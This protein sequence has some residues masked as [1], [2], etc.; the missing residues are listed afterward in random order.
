MKYF[1]I[2]RAKEAQRLLAKKVERAHNLGRVNNV[3]GLDVS[4]SK[5]VGTAVAAL[6]DFPQLSL[7]GYAIVKEVVDIPYIPGLLA[8]REAPLMIK[9]YKTLGREA[10]LIVVDGHGVTHPRE[11]GVASHVG[12]ALNKPTI[13]V[14]KGLLYGSIVRGRDGLEYIMVN[15]K[16]GGLVHINQGRKLYVSIGHKISMESLK[17]IIPQLF[18][19]HHLPEPIYIADTLSKK[20]RRSQ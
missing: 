1:D 17:L 16:V 10:D 6:L 3:V 14:A 8:F 19:S 5:N 13:G 9:A 20:F 11:F 12:L 2:D 15:D 7:K 4:Y 18:K